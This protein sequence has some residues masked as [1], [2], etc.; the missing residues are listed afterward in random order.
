MRGSERWL[1]LG[2][3]HPMWDLHRFYLSLAKQKAFQRKW[4]QELKTKRTIDLPDGTSLPVENKVVDLFFE[5]LDEREVQYAQAEADL[6]S[7]EEALAF[8]AGRGVTVGRTATKSSDH[9]QSSKAMIAAVSAIAHEV[10]A[11]HGVGMEPDPQ[12]RCVWCNENGLHVSA[13]NLDG[14][15]PALANPQI[16]WEIKEYWGKTSGGSKMS[17][18]VYECHLVGLELRD[19]EARG[20]Q[21]VTHIVFVDGRDQ[22]AARKS[23]MRR[24]ID[25]MNQGLVDYLIVGRQVE[26]EWAQVLDE[27]LQGQA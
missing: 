9:H 7:E 6:R 18:A 1:A 3:R 26:T 25:L 14:A 16:V 15:I 13:R 2:L 10:C 20:G 4:L 24:F 21:H 5:Y 23:D 19:Y 11:K 12:T 22:W 8:C 27:L 17:D